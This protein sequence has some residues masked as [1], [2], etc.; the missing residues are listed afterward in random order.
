MASSHPDGL[1]WS[2]EK[3]AGSTELASSGIA[4]EVA[5]KYKE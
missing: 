3:I 5:E 1:E 4:Y 2:I